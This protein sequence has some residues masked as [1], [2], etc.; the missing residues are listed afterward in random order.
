MFHV[1]QFEFLTLPVVTKA[2]FRITPARARLERLGPR[3]SPT[4]DL[5]VFG[6]TSRSLLALALSAGAV[7]CGAGFGPS[8]NATFAVHASADH[9]TTAGKLQF[10][11]AS[12]S[13]GAAKVDWTVSGGDN[14]TGPGSIDA[15]GVYTPP[16][17]TSAAAVTVE[18][19][20]ALQTD[21]SIR[22]SESVQVSPAISLAPQNIAA[23]P[24]SQT[25]VFASIAQVGG[26]S[27][28]WHL[29]NAAGVLPASSYGSFSASH[30]QSSHD[31][32][33]QCTVTYTAP[34]VL[35]ASAGADIKL[36]A[37]LKAAP[38]TQGSARLLLNAVASS[39]PLENEASQAGNDVLGTSGGNA[40]DSA[41]QYCCGGTLGALVSIGGVPY[42]LS[43]NHV[44]GRTDQAVTG[45]SVIQ[46]G[47]LDTDCG[48]QP[49][50]TVATLSYFP[51]LEDKSTNVDAAVAQASSGALDPSGAILGFGSV[52]NG[53]PTNA[54]PAADAED[55]TQAAARLPLVVKAGRTTGLTCGA[56]SHL[57]VDFSVS[58]N[59]ACD[60][61][62]SA[63]SKTFTNQI[64]IAGSSFSDSGDSGALLAD[65]QTAQ[66]VGLVFAGNS[67]E[68]FANP[69]AD[70]LRSLAPFAAQQ[71]SDNATVT[72]VGGAHHAVTC[73]QYD[74][75]A[76]VAALPP[77]ASERMQLAQEAAT[78]LRRTLLAENNGVL[79]IAAGASVDAPGE[80]ALVI[81]VDA[82][83]LPV[84]SPTLEGIR[85]VVVPATAAELAAGR[86]GSA[87]QTSPAL[88][89]LPRNLIDAAIAIKQQFSA[90]LRKDPAIFGVGVGK[91]FD[92]PNEAA[93]TIFV[94]RN[95]TPRSMPDTLGGL[96]V[97]Y[98]YQDA[99]RAFDWKRNGNASQRHASCV[100]RANP[101]ALLLP[102]E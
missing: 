21:P 24:G 25:R 9:T 62:G 100:R 73:L 12:F 5:C 31:T 34:A 28:A 47:L 58:Y 78:N 30:C 2:S 38:E 50:Y 52:A 55:I 45:E 85:T 84:I 1:E 36:Q 3:P 96:R 69:I 72:V 65:Q 79:D 98:L 43:N 91:S 40:H 76:V 53:S 63:F 23:T 57:A 37:A 75:H 82:A 18:V 80:A 39:S 56:I 68:T 74:E 13:G 16:A 88:S 49:A 101:D 35:P 11:A 7:G 67:S 99:P 54:P 90:S 29:A 44:L 42:V 81:Y 70:V 26:G 97:Q 17:Y 22:A 4:G 6:A 32:F 20:A 83:R 87:P 77:V 71:N 27:V 14:E 10:T 8:S 64:A 66:P 61:S 41:N 102:S 33:T 94:D 60:G 48:Y 19:T 15:N 95:Q 89:T 46:P 93:I 51:R 59:T 86:A 92:N